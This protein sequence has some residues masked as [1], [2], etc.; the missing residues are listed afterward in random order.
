MAAGANFV[1]ALRDDGLIDGWGDNSNGQ[2]TP[3]AWPPG[4][5]PVKIMAGSVHSLALLSN[6]TAVAWGLNFQGQC[7][8]PPLPP[9]MTWVDIA[10]GGFHGIGLRSDGAVVTWGQQL[11]F[12]GGTGSGV[13]P[14]HH[15]CGCRGRDME[16][17][18]TSF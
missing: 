4:V 12:A 2:R 10:A 7:S 16:H 5:R 17:V 1:L 14:G 11:L 6:G 18:R 9:G 15:L 8:I 13:A 3:P